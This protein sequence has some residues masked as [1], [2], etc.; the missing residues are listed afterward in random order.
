[1]L[2]AGVF[3]DSYNLQSL[4]LE[5]ALNKEARLR[6]LIVAEDA[7]ATYGGEAIL[8][9]H[10]FR[11]LRRRGIETWLLVHER[12][13]KELEQLLPEE[14]Q[15]ISFVRDTWFHKKMY[16]VARRMPARIAYVTVGMIMRLL[17]QTMAKEIARGL[18]R[19]HQINL[20]HQPTP[21]SP[22]DTSILHDLGVPL[23]IGPMNGGMSFPQAFRKTEGRSIRALV[24]VGRS[25]APV[26]HRLMPGKLRADALLVANDRT[27]RALPTGTRGQIIHL[28]ENGV[29]L[30]LWRPG[31]K[32][33]P[34]D[35]PVRFLFVGRLVDWKAVDLL[36]EAFRRA[37]LGQKATLD[38]FG[39]GPMD[40][41]L[42]QQALI[43]NLSDRVTFHGWLPQD[44]LAERLASADALVLPSL[45]ECGGAVVLE[46][47]AA[48]LAVI[49][50][51]WGGPSDYL[52]STCG[53]LV[54][55]TSREDFVKGLTSAI[56][57]LALSPET[58]MKLGAAARERVLR[59][60]SWEKKIERIIEIYVE[61]VQA[62]SQHSCNSLVS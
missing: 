50:T 29:D 51:N 12:T 14:L 17:T 55:P 30:S 24:A 28:V 2:V 48:G 7:S 52:D 33:K 47:M 21:V 31:R 49:A 62:R 18:I 56:Q 57:T 20:V 25:V 10:Y 58:R 59:E 60:F 9:L 13:R 6:I 53:I 27:R 54:D 39:S 34:A 23:I 38:I 26:F 16:A 41:S 22:K 1:L 8:P 36:L 3:G 42:R 46:A 61:T 45:L 11:F 43:L 5:I 44:E 37:G 40:E 4:H 15:R 35:D 32:D 19:R